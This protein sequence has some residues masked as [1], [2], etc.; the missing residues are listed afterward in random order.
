MSGE[1]LQ[2]SFGD[3]EA[4]DFGSATADGNAAWSAL[5]NVRKHQIE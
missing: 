5:S 4:V 3:R 1:T 2:F